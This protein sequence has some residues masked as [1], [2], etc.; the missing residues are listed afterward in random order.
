MVIDPNDQLLS[1]DD[2]GRKHLGSDN[3]VIT[4][5]ELSLHLWM[6]RWRISFFFLQELQV[7][8]MRLTQLAK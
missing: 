3:V 2:I 4:P 6:S 5:R 8:S 1:R 7:F